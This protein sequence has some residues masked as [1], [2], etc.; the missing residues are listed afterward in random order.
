MPKLLN[1]FPAL[2]VFM[3]VAL[4]VPL[5]AADRAEFN[6]CKLLAAE[7]IR[8]VQ[9]SKPISSR[10]SS[11]DDGSLASAQCFY[12]LSP[13]TNSVSVQV[14]SRSPRDRMEVRDFW[15]SKFHPEP[16]SE[17][18]KGREHEGLHPSP[19]RGEDEGERHQLPRP[20]PEIGDE[21]FWEDTG[22]GGGAIYVLQGKYVL[23]IS[24][25]GKDEVQA[26][27]SKASILAKAAL[28]HLP[29]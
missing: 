23:R 6:P 3:T 24:L 15:N 9:G 25:G 12:T 2:L 10:S 17:P 19:A 14:L 18:S 21:A 8:E 1:R 22:H 16:D 4:A 26:K 11:N 13:F 20:L 5:L 7:K 28:P 29:K 27:I